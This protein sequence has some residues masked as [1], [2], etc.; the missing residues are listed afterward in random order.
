MPVFQVSG[1][2]LC[3][4]SIAMNQDFCLYGDH[5]LHGMKT[6]DKRINM[7]Y[8]GSQFSAPKFKYGDD[9]RDVGV[10]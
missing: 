7:W 5:I 2:V 10:H 3:P 8:I 9:D 6:R 1:P 4:V